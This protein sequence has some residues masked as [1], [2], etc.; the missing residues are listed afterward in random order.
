MSYLAPRN[1]GEIY[2]DENGDR[3]LVTGLY[4]EPTVEMQRI[5]ARWSDEQPGPMKQF[6]GVS[7]LMWKGFRKIA[8]A[9]DL[10]RAR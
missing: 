6:G 4:L 3:W 10:K 9:P 5:E 7:G 1:P 2:E 8:D